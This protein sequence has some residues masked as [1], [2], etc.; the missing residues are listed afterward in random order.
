[1]RQQ[2][3]LGIDNITPEA[4]QHTAA[5]IAPPHAEARQ[6]GFE[7]GCAGQRRR[8]GRWPSGVY[9]HADYELG[10]AEATAGYFECR[11]AAE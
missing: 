3:S 6:A 11:R 7:D 5:K 8:A 1:M 4:G 2:L 9:G 10:F